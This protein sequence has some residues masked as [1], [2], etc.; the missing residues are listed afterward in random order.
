M[1][2]Q[3]GHDLPCNYDSLSY[4][5]RRA[6]RDEYARRQLGLCYL[7]G[8]PL[9]GPPPLEILKTIAGYRL[10]KMFSRGFFLYRVHLHHD[11]RTGETLGTVHSS[12]NAWLKIVAGE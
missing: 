12:C 2:S 9:D 8:C 3:H 10:D 11:H 5:E 6:V 7:C 1:S 4:A